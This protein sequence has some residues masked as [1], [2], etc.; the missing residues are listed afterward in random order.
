[1]I[2]ILVLVIFA[3]IT[4]GVL[5]FYRDQDE[6]EEIEIPDDEKHM[7]KLIKKLNDLWNEYNQMPSDSVWGA[8]AVIHEIKGV[9]LRIKHLLRSSHEKHTL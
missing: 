2:T 1:M 7:Q 5:M 3:T 9:E 4:L 6:V 8:E